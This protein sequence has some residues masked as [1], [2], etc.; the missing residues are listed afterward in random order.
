MERP[1]KALLVFA[2]LL[3]S[4][5]L[6]LLAQ[7]T[8]SSTIVGTVTDAQNAVVPAAEVVLRNV[9][10]GI[11][12]KATT[13]PTGEYVFPNLTAGNYQV[14]VAKQGFKKTISDVTPLE[15]GTT[16]RIN[17]TLQVGA[18]TEE[19]IVS[20]AA[21]LI[22]TDDAS[23]NQILENRM[24]RDMPIEGR[25][26]LNYAVLSPMF[27]SGS[28]NTVRQDWGLASPTMPGGKVLNLGGS[29]YSVGYY[30]DG[31]MNND[32][33][34]LGPLTNVNADAIQ[35]VK[36]EIVNYSAEYGRD[37][38][39]LSLTTKSGTNTVHGSVYDFRQV[40]GNNARDPY[41][42]VID[43]LRGRD[44]WHQDQW[45]FTV[46]GPVYI[47][48]VFDGRNKAF[49][50]SSFERLRRRGGETY[51]AYVPTERERNGDF[52]EWLEAYPGEPS[53][54][55]YDPFSFDTVTQERQP[56]TDNI[57]TNVDSRAAEYL[58]HF[59][60]PN[61]AFTVLPDG[62]YV[63]YTGKY[64]TG[65]NNDNFA[66]RIDYNLGQKDRFFFKYARDWGQKLTENGLIPELT[67]GSGP[68]HRT[69]T[70]NAHWLRTFSPTFTNEFIFSYFHGKNMSED[71]KVIQNFMKVSW[72]RNLLQNVSL[73]GGGLT[74]F[75]EKQ[76]EVSDDGIFSVAIGWPFDSLS[77]GPWEYWYQAI[78]IW[79]WSD[80][81]VKVYKSHTFKM[82]F[83]YYRKD[84]RDN[85][86]IRN[87][88]FWNGFT[89][90]GPNVT[91]GSGWN[92][93]A[94]FMTGAVGWQRQRT[95]NVGGDN[96]LWFRIPEW[97]W[98][99]NDTW[100]VN[101]KLTLNMG[102]RYELPI[103]AY[104]ANSYW[105]VMDFSYPG[106]RMVMPGTT[107]GTKPH[108]YPADKNNLLPRFGFAYR[109]SDNWVIRGGY[110]IFYDTGGYKYLD[111][112]FWNCPAY[113]GE[114]YNND[115]YASIN[116][117]DP[118]L[119]YFTFDNSFPPA[120]EVPKGD[121]PFPLGDK[122]GYL[123]PWQWLQTIDKDTPITPYYQRW[124]LDFQRKLGKDMMV[125]MG[126][127][128]S[129]GTKL[130]IGDDVNLPPEGIYLTYDDYH[131]A[132]PNSVLDGG[133]YA[134]IF[135]GVI[136]VHHGGMN[137][138][139]ALVTKFEKQW[140]HG[141]SAL[142]HHTW[143]KQT[144]V[145]FQNLGYDNNYVLGG[146]WHRNWSHGL[147]DAD[148]PHRFVAAVT[149]ELPFGRNWHRW[150]RALLAGWQSNYVVTFE[151]GNPMSVWN[152]DNTSYDYMG[153]VPVRTCNGNLSGGNRAF[154]RYFD[155]SC[156]QNPPTVVQNINGQDVEI[157]A[158]R[159]N[160]GRNILRMPGINN[161][162]ISLFKK[163]RIAE[164][165]SLDFRWEMFNAF[166]HPQWSSVNT[167]ND[168]GTNPDTRF[169]WVTG[170][171]NGRHIQFAL[172]FTF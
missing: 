9:D 78:P 29:E 160:A 113:G 57:I 145:T 83:Y 73:P 172:K 129:R 18:V 141:L 16:L 119:V 153:D 54:V 1:K 37:V 50:F 39:Q 162:D 17:M 10:T 158:Y 64:T 105:G 159:G 81:A 21:P 43:P 5:P 155:T 75:D 3:A 25:S 65:I 19:I 110:G 101:R 120:K 70:L 124:S 26:F 6:G 40:N 44:G 68:V 27:N 47:P 92:Y 156:F 61:Y 94:E 71:P 35:E 99:F 142:V 49:F 72:Y 86:I 138:Y 22:Q 136:A 102:L 51:L 77:L 152:G 122:A 31:F 20:A 147:S 89:G 55:I 28:G 56:Y 148:H 165:K 41:T 23:L 66:V 171:R 33:W 45:G 52:G 93:L 131:Y 169:G 146:Q 82:G 167:T 134:D 143:S 125:S 91:D 149:Y 151:S 76:L 67:L 14:E 34:V 59:P 85:D 163:F 48:K 154:E 107:P 53:M 164:N 127:T 79:Q 123:Y 69:N 87:A 103:P 166:N 118:N 96:S 109:A 15:N 63:N 168:T 4:S 132:R 100:Q 97:A 98:Y 24:V 130:T 80:N 42:K 88:G 2:L 62:R 90:R 170:G 36:T 46:G 7:T 140:S 112:M 135:D 13:N 117:G 157:A 104:S 144:D 116:L 11:T 133:A 114:E 84:E 38:G 161:W 95:Y 8:I 74:D 115:A 30:V 108:P 58:S 12:W 60:P 128:G 106:W 126:Y 139:H 32:N 121:W 150:A 137:D 111:Q